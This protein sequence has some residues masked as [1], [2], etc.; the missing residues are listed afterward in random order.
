[1]KILKLILV[2]AVLLNFSCDLDSD[3]NFNSGNNCIDGQGVIVSETR[4][5]N[6]FNSINS[7]IYADIIL[8]QGPQEDVIIE[9][10]ENILNEIE[11]TIVN[12]EL[13]LNLNR[14]V[15]IIE[16][17]KVYITIPDI[18][19]LTLTGVGR[20]VAQNDLSLTNLDITLTGVGDFNLKGTV[21]NLDILLTG[22]GDTKAFD[23][24]SEFCNVSITGVGDVEVFA[25]EELN[26]AITGVGDVFYMGSP[27]LTINI[28]GS[29]SVIDSN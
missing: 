27:D 21:N 23:L 2:L 17:V 18:Q 16:S 25:N 5:L 11:T 1:M 24:I 29:G 12:D 22:V 10:Q 8:T 15:D 26:V 7:A 19:S 3:N 13:R 9:A 14:C 6:D 28:T 4:V 20:F